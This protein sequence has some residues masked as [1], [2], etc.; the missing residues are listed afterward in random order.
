MEGGKGE[1]FPLQQ[2]TYNIA[3]KR[4]NILKLFVLFS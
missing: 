2:T 1:K 4:S 3:S